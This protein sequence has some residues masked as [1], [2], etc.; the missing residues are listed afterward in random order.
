MTLEC[1]KATPVVN[2][3]IPDPLESVNILHRTFPIA[4]GSGIS[5]AYQ[6]ESALL[7]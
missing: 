4:S 3:L 2:S 5:R 1:G 6:L 7:R